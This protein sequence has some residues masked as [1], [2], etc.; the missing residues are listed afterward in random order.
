[1]RNIRAFLQVCKNVFEVKET[2]LF[3]PLML[4][5]LSDFGKVLYT[6]SKLSN[7]PKALQKGIP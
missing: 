5:D 1:M 3:Q 2:D 7:S 4:L 6:L